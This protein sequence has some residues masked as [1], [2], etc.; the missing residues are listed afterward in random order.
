MLVVLRCLN[1]RLKSCNVV[2]PGL[3]RV[4]AIHFIGFGRGEIEI[5][6]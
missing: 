2:Q 5:I 4:V 3:Q 1:G 6:N